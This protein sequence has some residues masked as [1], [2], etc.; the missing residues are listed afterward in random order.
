MDTI[1]ISA[2]PSQTLSTTLNG[3]YCLISVR[4]KSTGV[5]L[6]L[7]VGTKVICAGAICLDRVGIVRLAGFIGQ[8]RFVDTQGTSDPDYTGFNARYK[9]TY[10]P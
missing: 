5:Y 6:D 10:Q 9:L 8:L 4:Q 3:Q 7:T 2:T 1:P